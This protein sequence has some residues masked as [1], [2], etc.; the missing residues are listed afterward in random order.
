MG[1]EFCQVPGRLPEGDLC[2]RQSDVDSIAGSD[3]LRCGPPQRCGEA[4]CLPG[5]RVK[6]I[7]CS[8]NGLLSGFEFRV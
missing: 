4:I 6:R 7:N 5:I 8:H 3:D 1:D 2:K